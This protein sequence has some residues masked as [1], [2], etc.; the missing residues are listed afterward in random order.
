VIALAAGAEPPLV[1]V[2]DPGRTMEAQM[3]GIGLM[4]ATMAAGDGK[5]MPWLM[6]SVMRR[7]GMSERGVARMRAGMDAVQVAIERFLGGDA[8]LEASAGTPAAHGFEVNSM[9]QDMVP[10]TREDVQPPARPKNLGYTLAHSIT[11]MTVMMLMFGLV[12]CSSTL[13]QERDQ[14]TLRRLL[15]SGAPR[16][17]LLLGKFLYCV[18]IGVLQL[19]ILFAYGEMVFGV[20]T[21]RDPVTLA[22]LAVTWAAAA[23]AFG[24][25][26][27]TWAKT[28]KQ[29]EGLST[30]LILVMAALGGCWFPLQLAELPTW[31]NVITHSTITHWAMTGFQGMFWHQKAWTDPVVLRAIAV[32]WGFV[33]VATLLAWRL[34]QRRYT[35][36]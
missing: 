27:A 2:R 21:F 4:Q 36:G 29:A 34:W 32:Q 11:G 19:A 5:S 25:L 6:S 20:G 14:G 22:V 3:V 23:T 1:L 7:H 28:Q 13:L 17:A 18:S 8:E 16:Q 9:F 30:M 35:A 26:I 12:A 24:M 33:V 31:A 15:V 10:V